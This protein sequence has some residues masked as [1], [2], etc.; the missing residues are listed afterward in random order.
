M[1][2][3]ISQILSQSSPVAM[4]ATDEKWKIVYANNK[5]QELHFMVGKSLDSVCRDGYFSKD[6]YSSLLKSGSSFLVEAKDTS[7]NYYVECTHLPEDKLWSITIIEKKDLTDGDHAEYNAFVKS[8]VDKLPIDVVIYDNELNFAYI[9]EV[10]VKDEKLRKWLIGKDIKAYVAYRGLPEAH[11]E[12]RMSFFNSVLDNKEPVSWIDEYHYT[13]KESKYMFRNYF[14]FVEDDKVLFL[15]GC[16]VDISKQKKI[17]KSLEKSIE[18]LKRQ[19][20]L[21]NQFSYVTSHNL[22]SHSSNLLGLSSVLD[23]FKE[24]PE[25]LYEVL[26]KIKK[27]TINLDTTLR[28]LNSV[29]SVEKLDGEL[30]AV[31]LPR[32]CNEI[33]EVL[34]QEIADS[35]VEISTDFKVQEVLIS[36]GN[37]GSIIQNLISNAI[38]YS[39]PER[40]GTI[41]LS[42]TAS[43]DTQEVQIGVEDNGIGIDLDR[44]G[45]KLFQLYQRFSPDFADGKGIGLF[46][47][48]SQVQSIGGK[49]DVQSELG[50]GTK[51]TITLPRDS[52]ILKEDLTI[53][54]RI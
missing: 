2:R 21:L 27:V 31:N 11:G 14:P 43:E 34:A 40:R 29:L 44:F 53:S 42:S 33:I 48:R 8:A 7:K 13:D 22:R 24:E 5:A 49:I 6:K 28:D 54:R 37:L 26:D 3:E 38:K 50:K 23:M 12:S 1:N 41:I 36:R 17:E 10:A 20:K 15:Y 4:I 39:S 35:N 47:V 18:D 19:N 25:K 45:A 46:L 32:F 9:N 30:S 52:K 51:F 16:G